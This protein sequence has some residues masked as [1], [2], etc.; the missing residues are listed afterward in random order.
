M[1]FWTDGERSLEEAFAE[2][3]RTDCSGLEQLRGLPRRR[4]VAVARRL[5]VRRKLGLLAA[6]MPKNVR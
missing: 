2:L 3:E 4:T 5:G 1:T 6:S